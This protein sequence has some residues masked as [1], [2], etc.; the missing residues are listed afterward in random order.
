MQLL[1]TTLLSLGSV[2]GSC[3]YAQERIIVSTDAGGLYQVDVDACHARLIGY[4][5][6]TFL[7][8]AFTPDGR[9]W[10]TLEANL[11]RI[12]TTDASITLIGASPGFR[13]PGLV[14]FNNDIL[15]GENNGWL[16]G[17]RTSDG[18]SWP[19]APIGY[20][21]SGDL[22]W[23]LGDLY[24]TAT[25]PYRLVRMHVE[26][27]LSAVTDIEVVGLLGGWVRAMV[28]SEHHRAGSLRIGPIPHARAEPLRSVSRLT[29]RC[30]RGAS[31]SEPVPLRYAWCRILR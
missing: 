30:Q 31:L 6:V 18:S 5:P 16:H 24:I 4:S 15:L 12:D 11:Y 1:F 19:I 29:D 13:T 20:T 28:R 25:G 7:D 14:Q 8:I 2:A 23:Y 3:V 27:D 26:P 9:L 10:G 17:I 21:V 22:T